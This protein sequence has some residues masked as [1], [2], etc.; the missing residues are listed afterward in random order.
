MPDTVTYNVNNHATVGQL[1]ALALRAKGAVDAAIAA[2]PVEMYLDA[3]N[4]KFVENFTWSNELYPGSTNPNVAASGTEGQ[5]GYVPAVVY[6][7]KPV[8]VLA[9]KSVDNTDPTSI[10][11][12]YSFLDVSKLVDTYSAASGDSAKVLTINGYT[13][14]FNVS[15][16]ANN[17]IT[18]E[19]DGL[20]VN[21]S[22][23][24]DKVDRATA[25]IAQNPYN[26]ET[27]AAAYAS[28]NSNY[29]LDGKVALLDTNGNIKDSGFTGASVVT[30]VDRASAAIAQNPYDPTTEASDYADFNTNY[31][32]NNKVALL[33]TNGKLKDS[34]VALSDFITSANVA[35]DAE[36][37][38]MLN[39]VFGEPEEG[40]PGLIDPDSVTVEDD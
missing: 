27:E 5:P 10:T 26:S 29:S 2:L 6:D 39:E 38:A 13:I 8:L 31:S 3:V 34:G 25:A 4:T 37:T 28:F 12:S 21:I 1:K 30:Q 15:S 7:G 23:K 9:V 14:T 33:D 17:A 11:T 20:H 16:A 40:D 32:L 35:S 19:N 24:A 36:V 18:V 22:A